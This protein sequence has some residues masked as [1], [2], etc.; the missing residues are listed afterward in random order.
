MIHIIKS[1]RDMVAACGEDFDEA[2]VLGGSNTHE[3]NCKA[4]CD[5]C[6]VEPGEADA[7]P[8]KTLYKY[9]VT[10]YTADALSERDREYLESHIDTFLAAGSGG[11][12]N[13]KPEP[14][15]VDA[16]ELGLEHLLTG[17]D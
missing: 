7:A 3:A 10:I 2:V 1:A 12:S 13:V 17:E 14:D 11:Q 8:R 4:C 16:E 15:E 9:A 5:E 6:G